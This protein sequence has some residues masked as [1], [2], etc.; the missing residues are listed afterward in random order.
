M[1]TLLSRRYMARSGTLSLFGHLV[2]LAFDVL[3]VFL[4][5]C[6]ILGWP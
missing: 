4:I 2:A 3:I 1:I 5:I 6:A